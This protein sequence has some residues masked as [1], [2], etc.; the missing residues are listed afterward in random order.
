MSH[1][2]YKDAG[3]PKD[4]LTEEIGELLKAIGKG[5]RFGWDNHHPERKTTNFQELRCEWDDVK[6]AYAA[7][8]HSIQGQQPNQ[9]DR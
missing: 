7:F 4:R 5:E 3:S 1:P 2:S 8:F 9:P 6:E